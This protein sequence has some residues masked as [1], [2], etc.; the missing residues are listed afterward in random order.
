[1]LAC[2]KNFRDMDQ[3]FEFFR[4]YDKLAIAETKFADFV[5]SRYPGETFDWSLMRA[6]L[7]L[8]VKPTMTPQTLLKGEV[9]AQ[10][11]ADGYRVRTGKGEFDLRHDSDGWY[12]VPGEIALEQIN[13]GIRQLAP[14]YRAAMLKRI[15][16]A[17]RMLE[18]DMAKLDKDVLERGV[19][20]DL[21]PLV[22]AMLGPESVP[23]VLREQLKPL[24]DVLAFY[25]PLNS[26]K[27]MEAAIRSAHRLAPSVESSL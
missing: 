1:M 20:E 10:K 16:L 5:K 24:D 6:S 2:E 8:K 23:Q 26:R 22:A 27:K 7:K 13:K 12:L 11:I 25:G 15:I 18:A 3:V 4:E 9:V 21:A 14:Y 19:N 17:Y